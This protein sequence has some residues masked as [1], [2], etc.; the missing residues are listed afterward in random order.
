MMALSE[1]FRF[2]FHF[3]MNPLYSFSPFF[4]FFL[5]CLWLGVGG[6]LFHDG[7]RRNG[8]DLQVSVK[9]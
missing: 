7:M 3:H 8:F 9:I 5:I 1:D 4:L 6:Q 2:P